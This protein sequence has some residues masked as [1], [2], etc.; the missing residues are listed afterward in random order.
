MIGVTGYEFARRCVAE[1]VNRSLKADCTDFKTF[2]LSMSMKSH[3]KV[4]SS[5]PKR[6]DYKGKI[7]HDI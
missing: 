1:V 7:F 4:N 5:G 2:Q 3:F 6:F